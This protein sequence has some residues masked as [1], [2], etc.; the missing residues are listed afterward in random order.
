DTG[1]AVADGFFGVEGIDVTVLYPKGRVSDLQ[2]RQI[3]GLGGNVRALAVEGSFDDCQRLV[4]E[5]FVSEPL[6]NRAA[7]SSANSINI[8]RLIPQTVY[9]AHAAAR[10][11]GAV[12]VVP[13]GNLGNLTAG[14]Y[15]HA[16]GAP[17]SGF[18][19]A[20]NRNK[21][22]AEYIQTGHYTPRD[23]VATISNAMDVG[24]PS[25]FERITS[26]WPHSR[27]AGTI[28]ARFADDVGTRQT[29]ANV[30]HRHNYVL[31][32]HGAV[33]WEAA[34]MAR[35]TEIAQ[36]GPLVI[37]ETAH[38]AKFAAVVEPLCGAVPLPASLQAALRRTVSAQ[39][40]PA[41]T[42]VLVDAL[43]QE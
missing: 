22:F 19:A 10:H 20:T 43:T 28:A 41:R 13:S 1:G 25:N 23:S 8:A 11:P 15:A 31:D 37:M 27:L 39:T 4:K 3:A 30:F 9:Y 35:K 16:L 6:K 36:R 42:A 14:L 5:A 34:R 40:I 2:E 17:L 18:I 12:I 29:I 21:T 33:G 7:L 32:P 24:A 38:P 26:H